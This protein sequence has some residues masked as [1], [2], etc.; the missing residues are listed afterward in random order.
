MMT[1]KPVALPE[2][3]AAA[4]TS[5]VLVE[6]AERGML[7]LTGAT[8]L[9]LIN[10]MSTQAVGGLKS[11]EGAA[12]VLTTD[13]GRIIDRVILYAGR[14]SVYVLTGEGHGDAL[15]RY[16]MR[17]IFFNDDVQPVSYTHLDVYKRQDYDSAGAVIRVVE[18]LRREQ[19]DVGGEVAGV[20]GVDQLVAP[21]RG[22]VVLS[23][24]HI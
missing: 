21:H 10:R 4:H 13:I 19:G 22:G 1:N 7:H 6:H 15:A 14:D 17:N 23:L 12:T 20:L 24:I 9:D 3:Y 8:R 11:G 18:H 16:F 5:A 2:A